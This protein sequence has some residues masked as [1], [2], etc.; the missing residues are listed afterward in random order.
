MQ[1]FVHLLLSESW[2]FILFASSTGP[3]Y[4][5]ECIQQFWDQSNTYFL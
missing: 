4:I 3:L 5:H 2:L 1:N